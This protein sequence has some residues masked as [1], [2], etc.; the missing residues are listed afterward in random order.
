MSG[1]A[2]LMNIEN[3]VIAKNVI[4]KMLSS[5]LYLRSFTLMTKKWLIFN[6]YS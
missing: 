5:Y 6:K 2:E 3:F 1:L 4:S